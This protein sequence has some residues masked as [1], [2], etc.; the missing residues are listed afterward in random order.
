MPTGE[1]LHGQVDTLVALE[2]MITV[3]RLWALIALEGPVVLW[4]L[5]A[6]VVCVHLA[7]HLVRWILH[8]HAAHQRHL[9]PGT[10]NIGHDRS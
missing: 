5:L 10:V 4:L 1:G 7:V 8:V 9:V 6:W 3:E 2:I